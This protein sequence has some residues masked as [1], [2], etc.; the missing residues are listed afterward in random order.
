MPLKCQRT[1]YISGKKN[2][3]TTALQCKFDGF[4]VCYA[5]I[6]E[7]NPHSNLQNLVTNT[8]FSFINKN[9]GQ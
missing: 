6:T 4:A 9:V 2:I 5:N 8:M 1:K 3:V 7:M